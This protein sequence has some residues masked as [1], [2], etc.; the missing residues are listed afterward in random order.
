MERPSPYEDVECL[1][2][3]AEYVWTVKD[4]AKGACRYCG[5]VGEVRQVGNYY[6]KVAKAHVEALEAQEALEREEALLPT[7]RRCG[8]VLRHPVSQIRGYGPHCWEIIEGCRLART[9]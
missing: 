1:S 7:C 9:G 5:T 4:Y 2:C 8:A 6:L 3:G